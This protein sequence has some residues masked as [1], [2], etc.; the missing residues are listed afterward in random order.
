VGR[1]SGDSGAG[2]E[3]DAA[4]PG[5]AELGGRCGEAVGASSR[6]RVGPEGRATPEEKEVER[7]ET[8]VDPRLDTW[9]S[10]GERSRALMRL[11]A[12]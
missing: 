11:V 1:R 9:R 12:P 8:A 5:G 7:P 6:P 4:S 2:G 10:R 3:G